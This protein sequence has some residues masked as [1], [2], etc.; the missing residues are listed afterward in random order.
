MTIFRNAVEEFRVTGII[1]TADY[2]D[3]VC[4]KRL[5][6]STFNPNAHLTSAIDIADL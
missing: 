2:A 4:S 5:I 3:G 6:W 1:P